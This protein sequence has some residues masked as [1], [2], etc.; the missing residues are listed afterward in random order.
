[1]FFLMLMGVSGGVL[2]SLMSYDRYVAMCHLLHYQV[3]MSGQGCL[4]MVGASW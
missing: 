2:L 4:V 3:L 1:M